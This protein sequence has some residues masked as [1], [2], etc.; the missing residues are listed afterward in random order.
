MGKIRVKSHVQQERN[1]S[2]TAKK[3]PGPAPEINKPKR[4]TP[5]VPKLPKDGGGGAGASS[6]S[7][8]ANPFAR[9]LASGD[10]EVRDAT[11]A[12]L[13]KW[14]NAR[15]DV[16]ML[17]MKKIWKGLFYAMWHAD[18]WDVQEELAERMG[19]AVHEMKHKVALC[20]LGVFY[21]TARREWIGI[22]RHRMDKYLRL[23]RRMTSHALRYCANRDWAEGATS[24]V[25]QMF[26]RAAMAP[27]SAPNVPSER[28]VVDVGLRLHLAEVFVPELR[29]V[30]AG[31]DYVEVGC[32]P[33]KE[34]EGN[35]GAPITVF[36]GGKKPTEKKGV[37]GA[38]GREKRPDTKSKD[39]K[40]KDA[41]KDLGPKKRDP[42]PVPPSSVA[43]LL[44]PF[45]AVLAVDSHRA[46][47]ERVVSEVFEAALEGADGGVATRMMDDPASDEDDRAECAAA[48][49]VR[50]D[51]ETLRKM[52]RE[53]I[54]VGAE[55]GVGDLQRESL[56]ALHTMFKRAARVAKA[57]VEEKAAGGSA[58]VAEGVVEKK[59]KNKV[60]AME[61]SEE[62]EEES[63]ASEEEEDASEEE[64]EEESEEE[65]AAEAEADDSFHTADGE[66][67]DEEDDEEDDDDDD[68]MDEDDEEE[69]PE[70]AP[71]T[72][73]LG[74]KDDDEDATDDS[75]SDSDS[76]E[77]EEEE[78]LDEF[79]EA[80]EFEDDGMDVDVGEEVEEEDEEEEEEEEDDSEEDSMDDTS[81]QDE[82]SEEE[83]EGDVSG[84][85][86]DGDGGE[87]AIAAATAAAERKALRKAERW[88][89]A[90]GSP[91]PASNSKH[92]HGGG[93]GASALARRAVGAV[94]GLFG[95]GSV[96]GSAAAMA[97]PSPSKRVA[98][99]LKRNT[100]HT[101]TGP[102]N[103]VKGASLRSLLSS[104]PKKGLLRPIHAAAA[105]G[106]A[107]RAAP[108]SAPA[109]SARGNGGLGGG[110][111]GEGGG[112]RRKS[113]FF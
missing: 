105:A 41:K 72:R 43:L 96:S 104:T 31:Q 98:W 63:E 36:R 42:K 113:G 13:A 53:F 48:I 8:G 82:S 24:D 75:D 15:K 55:P 57:A 34:N 70:S 99:N 47:H 102:P 89:A 38:F 21:I 86:S 1:M 62:E 26:T 59:Q 71:S 46:L 28:G 80:D 6:S 45:S 33:E 78:E 107:A 67:D 81:D 73:R 60:V 100:R 110:K 27:A 32:D 93:G 103:P 108:G 91:A 65:A 44:A 37:P 25:S 12:A 68:E 87:A 2:G 52:S 94:G 20:Y 109:K 111:Q 77:E 18:G 69:E 7:N 84:S 30:A 97:S 29:K 101:P 92:G 4:A 10:K 66:D 83:S 51:A 76:E 16:P 35:G 56:Y 22:D 79:E 85:E 39:K 61:E 11:F 40:T 112:N 9:Q 5:Y 3:F 19:E 95:G 23:V 64:E 17:D 74:A 50:L 106:M 49:M 54:D 14:L 58:V 90:V 88:A